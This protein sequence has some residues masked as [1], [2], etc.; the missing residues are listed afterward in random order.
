MLGKNI[1]MQQAHDNT[2]YGGL[3]NAYQNLPDKYHCKI[4]FSDLKKL[5]ECCQNC[6]RTKSCTQKPVGLLMPLTITHTPYID[7]AMDFLFPKQ[8]VV[9]CTKPI[10]GMRL[11]DN[12]KPHFVA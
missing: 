9:D 12:Q 7:I 11:S 2:A 4:S 10:L 6:E 5:V 1:F 8:S 3:D